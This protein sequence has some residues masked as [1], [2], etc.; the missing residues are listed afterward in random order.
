VD[1]YLAQAGP[2]LTALRR[3]LKKNTALYDLATTPLMLNILMLTYQ[4]T[5]VRGLSKFP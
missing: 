5:P 2:P 3:A 1:A 4:G